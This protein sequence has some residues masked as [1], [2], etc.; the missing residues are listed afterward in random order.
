MTSVALL[1]SALCAAFVPEPALRA[2]GLLMLASAGWLARHDIATRTVRAKGLTRY[3]ALCLLAGNEA[4]IALFIL[5]AAALVLSGSARKRF[6]PRSSHDK[7]ELFFAPVGRNR[8]SGQFDCARA[9][10]FDS[11]ASAAPMR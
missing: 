10:R 7:M 9:L 11:S 6:Q 8:N 5:T 4:A 2:G 3:I 1:V